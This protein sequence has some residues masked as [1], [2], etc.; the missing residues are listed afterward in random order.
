M[1]ICL[2]PIYAIATYQLLLLFFAGFASGPLPAQDF[3]ARPITLIVPFAQ[4]LAS[5]T[6][7]R[8][9]ADASAKHLGQPVVVRN[10]PG[11]EGALGALELAR[12]LK[13]DGYLLSQMSTGVYRLPHLGKADFDPR[14]DFTWIIGITAF[15]YGVAVNAASPWKTWSDFIAAAQA[16]PGKITYAV[17]SLGG[18]FTGTMDS[19]A[20]KDQ[21]EWKPVLFRDG[22]QSLQALMSGNVD[23]WTSSTG[24]GDLIATG[25]I[26]MLVSWGESRPTL[27]PE[28]PTLKELGYD[29]VVQ[30]PYGIAGPRN[31]DPRVVKILHDAFQK[32]MSESAF[33]ATIAKLGQEPWYRSSE[34]YARHSMETYEAEGRRLSQSRIGK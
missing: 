21:I 9:L 15:A 5:D 33:R 31:M 29:L 14:S 19:I 34:D 8:A 25:K 6:A 11:A 3:P 1:Q 28:V 17:S 16:Q 7:M 32:G 22:A 30:G 27:W 24:W 12:A 23:A 13:G 4:G 2:R 20:R 10:A 26:R 18:T